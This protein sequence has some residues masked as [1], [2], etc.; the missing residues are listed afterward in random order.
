[1]AR[2][3]KLNDLFAENEAFTAGQERARSY[4]LIGRE[5]RIL[6]EREGLTQQIL[7]ERAGIDQAE[8]SRLE[9]GKWGSRGI[10]FDVLG[11]LLPVFG[12]KISHRVEAEDEAHLASAEA[13]THLLV[14][15]A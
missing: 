8:I 9:C 2:T 12:L 1:M 11:R 4:L 6:R 5:M 3:S 14:H 7:A 15:D 13:I 10:S